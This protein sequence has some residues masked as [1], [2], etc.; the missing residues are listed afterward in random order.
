MKPILRAS[1]AQRDI[2]PEVGT[3]LAGAVGARRGAQT[4]LD[5]LLAKAI[6]LECGGRKLCIVS[7]DAI[8]IDRRHTDLIRAAAAEMGFEPEAVMVHPTQNHN[9]PAIS[10]LILDDDFPLPDELQWIACRGEN[11]DAFATGQ[12]IEAIRAANDALQPVEIG[13]GSGIEG[14]LAFNRRAVM[15]NGKV[16]MPG[17]TWPQPLGWTQIR[18]LEGP[19]DPEVGV[20][21]L[22]G[23]NAHLVAAFLSYTCHPVHMFLEPNGIVSADWPG[24]WCDALREM[25]SEEFGANGTFAVLN[26]ACGNINPWNPYDPEYREDHIGMGKTLA[27]TS[28][29]VLDTLQW[30]SEAV[31]AWRVRNIQIPL[32]EVPADALKNAEQL[33]AKNPRPTF[34]DETETQVTWDWIQAALLKSVDLE[35]SRSPVLDYEIQVLRIGN[36]ALVGLPGEPFVE[37]QL[38]IK[39]NSPAAHTYI[40]HAISHYAG[41]IPTREAFP[42]G[43]HEVN[44]S[45]WAKLVPEALEMI[46]ANAGELLNEVFSDH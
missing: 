24:A 16:M 42:R 12:I 26:G 40:V 32:R 20:I 6:V 28:R 33:L 46:V 11:Y 18:Y 45:T 34:S 30:Q 23:E 37:G 14:R 5:P 1:A 41:Y 9:A 7:M 22:R 38:E 39:L 8:L 21:A 3:T 2:T 44:L 4:F 17:N 15:R 19:I 25:T 31:L 10:H 35:R 29:I 27:Q 13:V 43:G 36:T